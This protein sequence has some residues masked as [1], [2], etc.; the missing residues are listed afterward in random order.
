MMNSATL[1][2]SVLDGNSTWY[3]LDVN[4]EVD[5]VFQGD[6][7]G[8]SIEMNWQNNYTGTIDLSSRVID[9]SGRERRREAIS[10]F[11][12]TKALGKLWDN[13]EEDA[14]WNHM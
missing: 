13:P 8:S 3:D 14:A 6:I 7:T 9:F 2:N 11:Y 12:S 4:D 1:Y 10:S 5:K